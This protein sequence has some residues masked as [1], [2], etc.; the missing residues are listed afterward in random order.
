ML[1]LGSHRGGCKARPVSQ[2]SLGPANSSC[3]AHAP[4]SILLKVSLKRISRVQIFGSAT[5]GL[6]ANFSMTCLQTSLFRVRHGERDVGW[7]CCS[8]AWAFTARGLPNW[9]RGLS[10]V[11]AVSQASFHSLPATRVEPAR[12]LRHL[13]SFSEWV[14]AYT[15]SVGKA[16][17]RLWPLRPNSR[18]DISQR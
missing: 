3:S 12:V 7:G 10:Q 15:S 11:M 13:A 4:N 6:R 9:E 5:K 1:P 18:M 8:K 2:I 17:F 14:L 16:L